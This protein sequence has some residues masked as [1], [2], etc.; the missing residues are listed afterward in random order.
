MKRLLPLALVW[1][2]LVACAVAVV[3]ATTPFVPAPDLPAVNDLVE[4]TL[5]RWPHPEPDDYLASGVTFTVA[6]SA[7]RVLIHTGTAIGDDR[8][9]Y[10]ERATALGLV[11]DGE[12]VGT[13]YVRDPYPQSIAKRENQVRWLVLP[14]LAAVALASALWLWWVD[15]RILRPF[16]EL[17]AFAGK[18][19]R[20]HLDAPLPVR[21]GDAFGAFSESF[22]ILR[23][24]LARSRAREAQAQQARRSLVAQLSHD[25]R[26]P[27]AT[28]QA[29]SEL[30]LLDSDDRRL[31][32]IVDRTG[33]IDRLTRDLLSA[34]AADAEA[35]EVTL[36]AIAT[37]DLAATILA[38]DDSG[39][40]R[41]CRLPECLVVG[42]LARIRQVVD[43]VLG[44][45]RKYAA[46]PVDVTG[47]LA[48]DL[49]TVTIADHGPGVPEDEV[50]L[51]VQRHY[52]AANAAGV[53]GYGL[54]LHTAYVLME[55]MGGTLAVA[56]TAAGFAVS[57][58]FA[59]AERQ[60]DPR[61]HAFRTI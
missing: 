40:V 36:G 46:P 32:V 56:N 53:R 15:R 37:T 30:L 42:D 34:N 25:I 11:R 5:A 52:R 28:I 50:A 31:H 41:E 20:G 10:A 22:D 8:Q 60:H 54:G 13:I 1:L 47:Q 38:A 27:L 14:V 3:R 59:C 7:G 12:R 6:D 9:A 4:T 61:R 29:T 57:L 44:N 51:I 26:T 17:Q 23:I 39:W 18:V 33:Q 19:A 21:K 48:D 2:T 16:R 43:N 49:L 55:A 45:A 35:M 24:E 58:T